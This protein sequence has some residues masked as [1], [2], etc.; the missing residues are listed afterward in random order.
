M[1]YGF[2]K[3]NPGFSNREVKLAEM[4]TLFSS[5]LHPYY[6]P[7]VQGSSQGEQQASKQNGRGGK[8]KLTVFSM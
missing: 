3:Q 4:K 8:F 2:A 5:P 7:N 6:T 1:F